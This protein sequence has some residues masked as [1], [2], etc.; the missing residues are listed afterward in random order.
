MN[1]LRIQKNK[2]ARG[3]LWLALLVLGC[4]ELRPFTMVFAA[5]GSS[6]RVRIAY[7]SITQF[8][9]GLWG[10]KEVGAF[11]RNGLTV[12][13][14]Y[15]S[16]GGIAT[17]ALLGGHVDMAFAAPNAAISA[18]LAGA[19]LLALASQTERPGMILWSQ[20]E[21]SKLEHLQ[22][23]TLGTTRFGSLNHFLTLS[24]LKKHGLEG[25]VKLQA[26]GGTPEKAIAF[27]AGI[28]AGCLSGGRP[29]PKA[30]ALIPDLDL[31]FSQGLMVVKK[32]YYKT[33]PKIVEAILRAYV[34]GVASMRTRKDFAL[35]VMK[36]YMRDRPENFIREDYDSF[37][38]YV[39]RVPKV[40]P[41][42]I[43]TV[44]DWLG[45][46]DVAPEQFFDNSIIERFER[47]RFIDQFY[48]DSSD[49]IQKGRSS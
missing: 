37:Y 43:H 1:Y 5:D 49:G 25:K 29:G 44:L 24:V 13:L 7:A 45:R 38:R 16:S 18:A 11:E 22:G 26:I 19:P 33:N 12:D 41:V 9:A 42:V 32:D 30:Y 46:L 31:P 15:I 4:L 39:L 3:R 23:K 48:R 21:I 2:V 34:E 47:D 6:Q 14:L 36:K 28:I 17:A 27:Q 10:A 8:V 40:N 35:S 20:P